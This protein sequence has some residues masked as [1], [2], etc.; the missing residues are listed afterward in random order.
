VKNPFAEAEKEYS[1]FLVKT[2][3]QGGRPRQDYNLNID[4]A[5][6]LCMVSRSKQGEEIRNMLGELTN[7]K[8]RGDLITHLELTLNQGEQVHRQD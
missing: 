2:P 1:H 5:K 4:F 7:D 6:K 8:E 3:N